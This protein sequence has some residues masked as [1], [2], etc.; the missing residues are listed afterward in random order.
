MSLT[1][2]QIDEW[3]GESVASRLDGYAEMIK[4]MKIQIYNLNRLV[5]DLIAEKAEDAEYIAMLQAAE[6][7]AK[8]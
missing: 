8:E 7:E 6:Q 5:D 2:D 4:S 1:Q 3:D